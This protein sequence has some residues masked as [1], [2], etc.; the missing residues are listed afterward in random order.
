MK[1]CQ[2]IASYVVLFLLWESGTEAREIHISSSGND[3]S[4]CS[5]SEP[6]K[7]LDHGFIVA[8]KSD[9]AQLIL[10]GGS[11]VLNKPH[12][13]MNMT[14]FDIIGTG[15]VKI[16]CGDANVSLSFVLCNNIS[17]ERVTLQ[18]CGGWYMSTYTAHKY[19]P[20]LRG[21][22]FKTALYFR[23]CRNLR[24]F[25][26]EISHSP[27]LGAN[28]YDVGGI[29]N[30]TNSV[31][32]NNS[33]LDD[34]AYDKK[35]KFVHSGGGIFLMLNPYINNT[36][37]VSSV[38]HDSYQH[39]NNY[40]FSNCHFLG[41]TA[42]WDGNEMQ[43]LYTPARPFTS[44]GGLAVFF[45][46][47]ASK[48]SVKIQG[49]KF[50]NNKASWGG[51]LQVE[52]RNF[53]ENN[54]V[55]IESTIFSD[56]FAASAGGGIRIG[57]LARKSGVPLTPNRFYFVNCSLTKNSAFWG[58]GASIFGTTIL[59]GNNEAGRSPTTQFHYSN[60]KWQYNN[61]S[62]GAAMAIYLYNY[63]EDQLGPE[64]PFHVQFDNGTLFESN[65]VRVHKQD[66]TTGQGSLYS[67]QVPLIFRD[68]TKFSSNQKS[69]V[70]L[71]G[72][73]LDVHDQVDFI[74]NTGY[75]GGAI[76]MYG[77]SRIIFYPKANVNFE[78]NTCDD[79]GG[80]LYIQIPGPPLVS[81]NQTGT[82][83]FTCFFGYESKVDYQRW[84]VNIT[85]KDNKCSGLYAGQCKGKS[86]YA[87]TL[88]TCYRVG[89]NR[90]NNS[91]LK[92]KFVKFDTNVSFAVSTDPVEL[93]FNETNWNVAP[94]EWFDA[95]VKLGDELYNAV[96]GIILVTTR[97]LSH[98]TVSIY[99][100]PSCSFLTN[101]AGK[102]TRLF[103]KGY[104]G[105]IFS[106][107]LSCIGNQLLRYVINKVMLR[108]CYDGLVFNKT[109]PQCHCMKST[110]KGGSG[111]SR[112]EKRKTV[113]IKRGFWAGTVYDKNN[114]NSFST[115]NCPEG[116]CDNTL[117]WNSKASD[118]KY[119]K[120]RVCTDGRD[121]SSALCGK[122]L[123]KHSVVIGGE[124]CS[125]T[126]SNWWLFLIIPYGVG[127]LLVVVVIMLIDLDVF[128]GYFN[129]WLYSY[130]VMNLLVPGDFKFNVVS[131]FMIYLSN[132][133]IRVSGLSFCFASGIDDADKLMIMYAIPVYVIVVVIIIAKLVGAYP[134]WCFS[135]RVRAPFRGICTIF[136]LCYTDIT[137]ISLKILRYANIGSRTVLYVNGNIDYLK[138][139]HLGYG[140][141]A[142]LVILLFVIPIPT[143]LL[144]RSCLTRRLRPV[145]NL[146][147]WNPFFNAF[148][149]CFK[150][151]YR[152][153]AAFY[154]I[155]RLIILFIH[156]MISPG[157]AKRLLLE[158]V[159]VLI[160]LFFAF[161]KPYKEAADVEEDEE[162][163]EW[164]NKS[165]VVLLTTLAFITM[166]RSPLDYSGSTNQPEMEVLKKL[167]NILS[168]VPAAVL[169]VI[170]ATIVW[171]RLC[172]S[173]PEDEL[174]RMSTTDSREAT[175]VHTPESSLT[176]LG[177]VSRNTS[178]EHSSL[179]RRAQKPLARYGS[180]DSRHSYKTA[181]E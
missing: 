10:D 181:E 53:S 131:E 82:N 90:A 19:F 156:T 153:C 43:E 33:G 105:S 102:I 20:E 59:G 28:L 113:F 129:A 23:Y 25:D 178:T 68:Y 121:P 176:P 42:Q 104:E 149:S 31:F 155:C 151:K 145:L 54:T 14:T 173:D 26:V 30:F 74:N 180:Q 179:L 7:T 138:G 5:R 122:C 158:G 78:G 12:S 77:R 111:I 6:C 22:F 52:F 70:M 106:L 61:G 18:K 107:H 15:N 137:S 9:S 24:V 120:N 35:S 132:I 64:T 108:N 123:E 167:L 38:E 3:S 135:R 110:T 34:D 39:N 84:N 163:Y 166:V 172:H 76:A 100:Q 130:Q 21:A 80:A 2:V 1:L 73:F 162:N 79:K 134:Q 87:T 95:D 75:R 157:P 136:V 58:G 62:V 63:N 109:T 164:M 169:L 83:V 170:G 150:D 161:L 47:N 144:F 88:K 69:A 128:T 124:E 17:M 168:C 51:G 67:S 71:D 114:M 56:N 48:C 140:I 55:L 72:S 66:V 112:C 98:G 118:Y 139:K 85:F 142:I 44:G 146:N 175:P 115:Y 117:E 50:R 174:P 4:N 159:C 41:N 119:V 152:W 97:N 116:Y 45:E 94:G 126:C 143:I 154:F 171:K 46:S 65:E 91:V 92:W 16:T 147:R 127:F 49:C 60:C 11:Y 99:N 29:V 125:S 96:Q 81:F 101:D 36:L 103:L 89:E 86:V 40:L 160:V 93:L 148:Q 133:R 27:G 165:V 37:N 57:N 32:A 13:F 177:G 141:V 8:L